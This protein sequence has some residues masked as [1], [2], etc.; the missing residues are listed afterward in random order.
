MGFAVV[1][2]G[3]FVASGHPGPGVDLPEPV[4]LIESTDG[5]RTWAELSRGGE[6]D[7]H[8]LTSTAGGVLGY[9]G[10][11]LRSANGT[12][13]E[14]LGMP[15]TPA[16]LAST[17]DGRRVLAT[18][19]DGVL[20]SVDAGGSWSP[21]P[22]APVLQFVDWAPDGGGA[23]GIDP[24][25]AVWVSPDSAASWQSTAQLDAPQAMDVVTADDGSTRVLIVTTSAIVESRDGGQTFTDVPQA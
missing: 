4:G 23:V 2:P 8:A 9:D 3:H 14:Q 21:A 16:S 19:E 20:L 11:L 25:G 6:S 7:F 5:G 22:G 17:D 18:T 10:A 1:G 24:T 13:W 15:G 12:D